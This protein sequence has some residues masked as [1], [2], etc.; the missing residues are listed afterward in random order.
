MLEG[1]EKP[2]LG[3]DWLNVSGVRNE[4]HFET[5]DRG[6]KFHGASQP[7]S[8]RS[9]VLCQLAFLKKYLTIGDTFDRRQAI[10]RVCMMALKD[11]NL[12]DHNCRKI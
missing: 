9:N 8:S 3:L 5:K 10:S 2:E 4:R 1:C 12:D 11:L 7:Q 6:M